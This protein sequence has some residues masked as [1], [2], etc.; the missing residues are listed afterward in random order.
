MASWLVLI[1]LNM[2]KYLLLAC[3][4]AMWLIAKSTPGFA[5]IATGKPPLSFARKS[6][7]KQTIDHKKIP[8]QNLEHLLKQETQEGKTPF[9]F[10]VDVDVDLGLLNS[11]TWEELP[12]GD[13][14]WKL[15]ISS[16]EAYSIN[17]IYGDFFIPAGASLHV[18]NPLRDHVLGGF[19]SE[20]NRP[21]RTFATGLV[22]GDTSI[23]EYYEP[24]KQRGK[25]AVQVSKV[26]HGYKDLLGKGAQQKDFGDSESCHINVKCSHGNPWRDQIRSVALVL[27][28]NNTRGCTGGL[29]NNTS[30]KTIPYFL[31]ANHCFHTGQDTQNWIFMFNY[32][33]PQ[34]T[35]SDGRTQ[36][37]ILGCTLKARNGRS[38]FMLL[39]LSSIPPSQYEVYYAGWSREA[40]PPT[41]V[42]G[43]HHPA[44]D[45]K[46]ISFSSRPPGLVGQDYGTRNEY[47]Q[48]TFW[49]IIWNR[50]STEG[51]SSGSLL[52]DENSRVRG[53]LLGGSAS[54]EN[55]EGSDLYGNLGVSFDLGTRR[56]TRLSDWLDPDNTGVLFIDGTNAGVETPSI[57]EAPDPPILGMR[58]SSSV[59]ITWRRPTDNGAAINGYEL[60][61]REGEAGTFSSVYSGGTNLSHTSQNLT[62]GSTYHYRVRA[63]NGV[64]LSEFSPI[65]KVVMND[66]IIMRD[67]ASVTGCDRAFLDP[68]GYSSYLNAINITMTLAPA[69]SSDKV[70]VTFRS[71]DTN[72]S[73]LIFEGPDVDLVR[74]DNLIDEF[75][76]SHLPGVV[77]SASPDGKL[78]FLLARSEVVDSGWEA[79]I[80]CLS[81]GIPDAPSE[82]VFGSVL[83]NSVR[84]LWE[85]PDSVGSKISQYVVE[86][87]TGLDG[88]FHVVSSGRSDALHHATGL[89]SGQEYFF[90]V[91][92]VNTIGTSEF[93]R[94]A[95]I[96]ARKLRLAMSS[97]E[98]QECD[99][100]FLDPGGYHQY[101]GNLDLTFTLAPPQTGQRVRVEFTRFQ[102]EEDVDVLKV[103]EGDRVDPSNFI[104]EMTGNLFDEELPLTIA[105]G[106][107]DGK[108]TFRFISD[109]TVPG[110]GWGAMVT[111]ETAGSTLGR[112]AVGSP[113]VM[114]PAQDPV[115]AC[116]RM[117]LDPGGFGNYPGELN[118]TMTLS[119]QSK[120][121]KVRLNFL[122]F[123]TRPRQDHLSIYDGIRSQT[124]A[125][126]GN[127][128]G[129]LQPFQIT[130]ES[131]DGALTL[132]FVSA[133]TSSGTSSG[134]EAEVGCL[135]PAVPEVPNPPIFGSILEGSIQLIWEPPT[136]IGSEITR[137]VVEQ[138][139]T[140]DQTFRRVSEGSPNQFYTATGL[141][142]SKEY[143]FRIQAINAQGPSRFSR[144]TGITATR[145][146]LALISGEHQAC[147]IP[148][149]DPGGHLQY[150]HNLDLTS[151][152]A[153]I[154]ADQRVQVLLGNFETEQNRDL[155]YIYH[156]DRVTPDKLAKTV[157][158]SVNPFSIASQSPDGKLTFRFVSN[159]SISGEGWTGI[160]SCEDALTTPD[161]S[162]NPGPPFPEVKVYPNPAAS[163]IHLELKEGANYSVTLISMAGQVISNQNIE[164]GGL[165][166]LNVEGVAEGIYILKVEG[167]RGESKTFRISVS[168][169]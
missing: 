53:Q 49:R 13:R 132:E 12:N 157:S 168:G 119:P 80:S 64:G 84:L 142:T 146:R 113:I 149:L 21:G 99:I 90:R 167:D 36:D 66:P 82:P 24:V 32:E 138:R 89:V 17:L 155:L 67:G 14:I 163:A 65:S 4:A 29:L 117:F 75:I 128:S 131:H 20:N 70:Q 60:Q 100:P 56:E 160:V 118:V 10:G 109:E 123:E 69:S 92:A 7:G 37:T 140:A 1:P 150:F 86:Q 52:F 161:R 115:T 116:D 133:P 102:M 85:E 137:Y 145:Q 6:T 122:S 28:H 108:L 166:T 125:L 139:S 68:G 34:C 164:E 55:P 57:P 47:S 112:V 72:G 124:V 95:G 23:L 46:K 30:N 19:T 94:E 35:S 3:L 126:R 114:A 58:T 158:G 11:G 76:G 26:I 169:T 38:D 71:F 120:T 61:Q 51:G 40:F 15:K 110:E 74:G 25:G 134:W 152:L 148:F 147:D 45:V 143:F 78:T 162:G 91:R 16:P 5:Q 88:T 2:N 105:S 83:A 159:G 39:E 165:K 27:L 63:S 127:Y 101:I 73:L 154:N 48:N 156:G 96:V 81:P 18:Y 153:P 141:T 79:D 121:G 104:R 44:G 50:G 107:V 54:C 33:S 136:S 129:S 59:E 77:T 106:S 144:E 9:Q 41:N 130:S 93:S 87:K 31:T 43:I 22:K 103:Y 8:P 135:G 111:C 151:T 98:V 42:T 97:G 62:S